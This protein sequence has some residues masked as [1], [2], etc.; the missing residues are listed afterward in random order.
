MCLDVPGLFGRECVSV[1]VPLKWRHLPA[2]HWGQR[3]GPWSYGHGAPGRGQSP[4]PRN[5]LRTEQHRIV[6][7]TSIVSCPLGHLG[8]RW[9][10]PCNHSEQKGRSLRF[11][12]ALSLYLAICWART[13]CL[14][15]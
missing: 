1:H 2:S 10:M 9:Q 4:V 15:C 11:L 12:L 7:V 6:A 8:K 3:V 14:L 13:I 5:S